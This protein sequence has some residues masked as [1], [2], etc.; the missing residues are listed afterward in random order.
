LTSTRSKPT[1]ETTPGPQV[2]PSLHSLAVASGISLFVAA[3][4]LV[5]A[6][7]PA[8]Y[9]IDPLGAGRAFGFAALSQPAQSLAPVPPPQGETLAPV[10]QGPIALYPGEYRFDSREFVLGPYEYL[11]YKY[12]LAKDATMLFSW[13]ADGDVIHDMHGDPDGAPADAAQSF[14]KQP[15]RRADGSFIAPFSGIHGWFW[16]NPGGETLA[17]RVTTAGFYTEAHEF[18]FDGTR[19]ER[20]VRAIDSIPIADN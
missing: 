20:E 9:G 14:D 19:Q 17:V 16:E 11:E 7:L 10:R 13:T 3:V 12:H 5:V 18:R 15:R 2:V 4:I 1:G 6:V 8:E